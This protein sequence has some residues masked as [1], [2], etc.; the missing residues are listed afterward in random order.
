MEHV[1]GDSGSCFRRGYGSMR[2]LLLLSACVLGCLAVPVAGPH[3][4]VNTKFYLLD[5]KLPESALSVAGTH[6][7]IISGIYNIIKSLPFNGLKE[8]HSFKVLG[9]SR[10]SVVLR[11]HKMTTHSRLHLET[12]VVAIE[13]LGTTVRNTPLS[14]FE[15]WAESL[16]G[17]GLP[18]TE[19]HRLTRGKPIPLDY[20]N[21]YRA[22]I[23][24]SST[25]LT[26]L[27]YLNMLR[28]FT[29]SV[30]RARATNL[31]RFSGFKVLG[32]L[33]A[34][35]EFYISEQPSVLERYGLHQLVPLMHAGNIKIHTEEVIKLYD[36]LFP[37][38]L[39]AFIIHST[40]VIVHGK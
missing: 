21:V 6:T 16:I 7:R 15:S 39:P 29:I 40:K 36:L 38:H 3:P 28:N 9:E 11:A 19:L 13:K 22:E 37:I 35:F 10:L 24:F 30:L 25:G 32:N 12:A 34:A 26:K 2:T 18:I 33:P 23:T 31:F 1:V 5:I 8:V 14:S 17:N 27:A 4:E 20:T